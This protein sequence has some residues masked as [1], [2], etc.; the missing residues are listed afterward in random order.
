MAKGCEQRLTRTQASSSG[1]GATKRTSKSF[2]QSLPVSKKVSVSG[3]QA[4]PLSTS[5]SRRFLRQQAGGVDEGAHGAASA[6]DDEND[7]AEP[8]VGVDQVVDAFQ[9]VEQLQAPVLLLLIESRQRQDLRPVPDEFGQR[10]AVQRDRPLLQQR[11]V[12]QV[13][14]GR[15]RSLPLLMTSA[16]PS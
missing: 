15:G 12:L 5:A 2:G 16:A 9:L 7:V 10:R 14:P 1:A 11:E 3:S 13:A 4:M 6:V 8:D